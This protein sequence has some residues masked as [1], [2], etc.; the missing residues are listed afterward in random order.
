MLRNGEREKQNFRPQEIAQNIKSGI[1]ASDRV[2]YSIS[3]ALA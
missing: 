1:E 3:V 2:H